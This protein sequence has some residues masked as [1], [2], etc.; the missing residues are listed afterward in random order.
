MDINIT[1]H[2]I[3]RDYLPR[4]ARGRATLA[5]PQGATV[6][7]VVAQLGIK[8]TV[9]AVVNGADVEP[10]HTLQPGDDLQMFRLIAGG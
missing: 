4:K 5:L 6:S 7:D 3:L 8:Q 9:S 10:D 2:G 1:L